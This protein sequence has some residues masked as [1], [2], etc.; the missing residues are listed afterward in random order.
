[1]SSLEEPGRAQ[2]SVTPDTCMY[3][4]LARLT[5]VSTVLIHNLDRRV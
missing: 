2:V 5:K 3:R 4:R 1:M